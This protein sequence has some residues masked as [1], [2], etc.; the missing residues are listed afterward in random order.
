[1]PYSLSR[2]AFLAAA[3]AEGV[4][5][6]ACL[7]IEDSVPGVRAAMAAGMTCLGFCPLGDGA[8]LIAEG[9]APLHALSDLPALLRAAL[10]DIE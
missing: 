5:P 8:H 2:R 1:M 4:T 10:E 7:V 6:D 3:A 9:A